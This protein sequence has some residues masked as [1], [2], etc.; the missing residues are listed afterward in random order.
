MFERQRAVMNA[1][2]VAYLLSG[3]LVA[4]MAGSVYFVLTKNPYRLVRDW[5]RLLLQRGQFIGVGLLA[6]VLLFAVVLAALLV[7]VA[8][9]ARAARLHPT[10]A[11][12]GGGLLSAG[13]GSLAV[14][15]VRTG[16][17]SSY[18]ALQYRSVTDEVH[19]H[20]LLLEAY[21]SEHAVMLGFWCFLGFAAPGFY[22]LGRALRGERGWLPDALKLAAAL[23]LLHL[24]VS[25][26]LARESLLEDQY[27]RGLAALDMFLLWG[28]LA[29]ACYFCARWLRTVGRM[30]PP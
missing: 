7:A 28:G 21:L 5:D 18:A 30:L 29:G 6:G 13:L 24:P 1:A 10:S 14:L 22:L 15:A 25:L 19:K 16:V 20:A 4:L 3:F 2:G 9:A 27:P 17:V 23:I 26:Y 11:T 8:V 12:V